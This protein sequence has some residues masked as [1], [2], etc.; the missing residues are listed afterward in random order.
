MPSV[1]PVNDAIHSG[2][3]VISINV[4]GIACNCFVDMGSEVTLIRNEMEEKLKLKR[5][6]QP[7]FRALRSASG[8]SF[9]T[10]EDVNLS[11]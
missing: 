8:H 5:G 3:P 11:F 4:N 7:S 6:I 9:R 1:A 2:R 10:T